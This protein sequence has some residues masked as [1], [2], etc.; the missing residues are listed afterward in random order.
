MTADFL[1]IVNQITESS[2]EVEQSIK[3]AKK[4]DNLLAIYARASFFDQTVH[5]QILNS[6]NQGVELTLNKIKELL[7][8]RRSV[9]RWQAKT[10]STPEHYLK[11]FP[12]SEEMGQLAKKLREW[13]VSG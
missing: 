13:P 1:K 2:K 4:L 10:K 3:Q 11:Y 6:P 5:E 7:D 9:E 8:D 12:R